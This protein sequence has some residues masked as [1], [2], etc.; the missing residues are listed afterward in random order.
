MMWQELHP[1]KL[2]R[3]PRGD[4]P[5][6]KLHGICSDLQFQSRIQDQTVVVQGLHRIHA[7]TN[8]S[9]QD[10]TGPIPSIW[11]N[12]HTFSVPHPGPAPGR[13]VGRTQGARNTSV[14]GKDLVV[15]CRPR[16][17]FYWS[18]STHPWVGNAR[19]DCP[20]TSR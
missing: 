20:V 14:T 10:L 3:P 5:K 1:Q 6:Q 17:L 4:L 8:G 12:W 16:A 19:G 2:S 13:L 9:P 15:T 18:Y 7:M 11:I